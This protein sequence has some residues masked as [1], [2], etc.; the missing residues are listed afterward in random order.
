M[1]LPL[2]ETADRAM[3]DAVRPRSAARGRERADR[4]RR[5]KAARRA[6]RW[7]ALLFR[8]TVAQRVF[9]VG[10]IPITV[11][12]L[13]G[14]AS[15]LLLDRADIAR[16]GALDAATIYRQ[17]VSG[18]SA[19]DAY[20]A[21]PSADRARYA[22][23]FSASVTGAAGGLSRLAE[24]NRRASAFSASV[25]GAAGTLAE[26]IVPGRSAGL[27]DTAITGTI[28]TLDRYGKQ[29]AELIVATARNDRLFGE[30]NARLGTLV[31]LTDEARL[32]Q[33]R[34]NSDVV[35]T[36]KNRNATL[37]LTR[38]LV[39]NA[40]ALRAAVSDGALVAVSGRSSAEASVSSSFE[41]A[42]IRNAYANLEDAL[43]A[44]LGKAGG[45][46]G[47]PPVSALDPRSARATLDWIDRR[48]KIDTTAQNALQSEIAELLTY[49]VE[50]HETEQ[51]T[52]NIAV[53]TL[54]LAKRSEDVIRRRASPQI[55]TILAESRT[56]GDKISSLPI[57]PLIQT[58][59]LDA[60]DRWSGG[61][62]EM[63]NGLA[64]QNAILVSMSDTAGVLLLQ[65]SGLNNELSA[66]A[67]RIGAA[68]RQII[69][70]GGGMAFVLASGAGLF[71]ARSITRPLKRLE[72][73]MNE[74]AADAAGARFMPE[75]NR[76]D[77]LGSMARATNNFLV[78]ID[79]REGAL[80]SAKERTEDTLQRLKDTQS[81]LIQA[82]KLASLGNLV[83]G[84]AH[85]INTPLGVALTTATVMVSDVRR[86]EADTRS[87]QVSFAAFQ[88]FV[89]RL[90]EGAH[91]TVSNVER[92][93][94]LVHSFKQVAADQASGERRIFDLAGFTDDLFTS[95][96][97]MGKR[98]GHRL[99]VNCEA[100]IRM[101]SYPG[102]LAQVLTN[103]LANAYTHAFPDGQPGEI[104]VAVTRR[105]S[106][107]VRIAFADN[108]R[109]IPPG[110]RAKVFDPFFT[111]GRASGSTGL[112]LHIVYNLVTA[113]LGGFIALQTRSGKG[114]TFVLDLPLAAPVHAPAAQAS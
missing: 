20:V 113:T 62:T 91:L 37:R 33:N 76:R 8:P 31:A 95:L 19:R 27:P 90:G 111:T 79:K 40:Q 110:N 71:V 88:D 63:Q 97:P 32:R 80:R 84:V 48:L 64:T 16:A 14:V 92:A 1:D 109:G 35:E 50:A 78:E 4:R 39:E 74:R 57:S 12:G 89:S 98:A 55:S 2:P 43:K 77:E 59:M 107:F 15:I 104:D 87:G 101:D 36:L 86:F 3:P 10:A 28:S 51:A 70:V 75:S 69:A 99:M 103:L 100:N 9:L 38:D 46:N 102:A 13:I 34:S 42:R 45:E 58:D 47:P 6:R 54:K 106:R 83:A 53:D 52:Q 112:G 23:A 67:D 44:V 11:M 94:A 93:A 66:N 25:L 24:R 108:G 65:V 96:G 105:G 72:Q 7:A 22:A 29:M 18:M 114:T 21:A 5:V 17:V 60:L 81:E 49:T 26:P 56:I 61:L 85:E 68:V 73:G 82:E 41:T 30:M